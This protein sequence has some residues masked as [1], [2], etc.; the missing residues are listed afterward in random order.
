MTKF[1]ERPERKTKNVASFFHNPHCKLFRQLNHLLF[2]TYLELQ[3]GF[4]RCFLGAPIAITELHSFKVE[5][6]FLTWSIK[7]KRLSILMV[8]ILSLG[9]I[10]GCSKDNK[11]SAPAGPGVNEANAEMNSDTS[12]SLSE[13]GEFIFSL[14]EDKTT[15]VLKGTAAENSSKMNALSSEDSSR[16]ADVKTMMGKD[17]V[18]IILHPVEANTNNSSLYTFQLVDGA[19]Q[20]MT[21]GMSIQKEGALTLIDDL[22]EISSLS[23]DDFLASLNGFYAE[24]NNQSFQHF[25][26]LLEAQSSSDS[27]ST[28]VIVSLPKES[29]TGQVK[30]SLR[31]QVRPHHPV[32]KRDT[33][34]PIHKDDQSQVMLPRDTPLAVTMNCSPLKSQLLINHEEVAMPQ[35][36]ACIDREGKG[37]SFKAGFQFPHISQRVDSITSIAFKAQIDLNKD[38]F[39]NEVAYEINPLA[40]TNHRIQ[41]GQSETRFFK[42]SDDL[43]EVTKSTWV[44]TPYRDQ[45]NLKLSCNIQRHFLPCKDVY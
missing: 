30:T 36:K 23:D 42:I 37:L 12:L 38:I 14:S 45:M 26:T 22:V 16:S 27:T 10:S 33:N 29:T 41:W 24:N 21:S 7:M 39:I 15:L 4:V 20:T 31:P 5:T 34:T 40:W 13:Q 19:Y 17:N 11:N 35:T 8:T 1:D 32:I 25:Y 28:D 18:L 43:Y 3:R 9:L 2:I 44:S 6:Y